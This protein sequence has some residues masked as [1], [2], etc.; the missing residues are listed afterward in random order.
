MCSPGKDALRMFNRT[1]SAYVVSL[2]LLRPTDEPVQLHTHV[3][4]FYGACEYNNG[5]CMCGFSKFE[6]VSVI[7][8]PLLAKT[9]GENS[10]AHASLYNP[11]NGLQPS[12]ELKRRCFCLFSSALQEL[13]RNLKNDD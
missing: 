11:P 4:R 6:V 12:C 10:L 9:G 3:K 5:P 7:R 8:G 1:E 13:Y 2:K